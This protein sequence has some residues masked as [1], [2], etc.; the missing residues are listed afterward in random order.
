MRGADGV[1]G[2]EGAH[3]RLEMPCGLCEGLG[4]TILVRSYRWWVILT[5]VS[6]CGSAERRTEGVLR[7]G[8]EAEPAPCGQA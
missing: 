3:V 2:P 5:V 7:Q 1:G 6:H 4:C 8:V